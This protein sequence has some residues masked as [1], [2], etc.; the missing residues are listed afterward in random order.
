MMNYVDYTKQKTE[1]ILRQIERLSESEFPHSHAREGLQLL[2]NLF[3]SDLRRIIAT[4][5]FGNAIKEQVCATANNHIFK[6][7]PILGFCLRSTNVRNA[8]ELYVPLLKIAR[9]LIS[10]N[11]KLILSSEWVFSPFTYPLVFT[12][13]PNYVL[14]GLPASES[15]NALII[16]LAGHELG[17]SVWSAYNVDDILKP[18]LQTNVI[19]AL[20]LKWSDYKIKFQSKQEIKDVETDM[21]IRNVWLQ[22]L[23][24]SLRQVQEVFCDSIGV[25]IFG[26]SYFFATE[27]FLSPNFGN[28]RA[29]HYPDI[30]TRTEAMVLSAK[31]FGFEPPDNFSS[32]FSENDLNL[33]V[34]QEFILSISDIAT[35]GI[36]DDIISI[37]EF[38]ANKK[39]LSFPKCS[40]AK[41]IYSCFKAGIPASDVNDLPE[42]INAGWLAYFDNDLWSQN[43]SPGERFS[44]L[45]EL[46]LKTTEVLEYEI[47]MKA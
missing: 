19:E 4:Q 2:K 7:H 1:L 40:E 22:S 30:K 43:S 28:R 42:I 34:K 25:R 37:V 29:A 6:F 36:V 47:R 44:P 10:E 27:Y 46:I 20:K 17:H 41:R 26:E 24:L 45:N 13:L 31:K 8:F 16:P 35:E 14:I 23:N 21:F 15:S 5:N 18:I 12:E 38:I 11:T 39:N 33:D 3:E 32:R 9:Q